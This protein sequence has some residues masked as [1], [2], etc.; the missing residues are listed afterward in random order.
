MRKVVC[1]AE[2]KTL[3]G[4]CLVHEL[5]PELVFVVSAGPELAVEPVLYT[6][7]WSYRLARVVGVGR[8]WRC[9]VNAAIRDQ[10]LGVR[11]EIVK[12]PPRIDGAASRRVMAKVLL[13]VT[14]VEADVAGFKLDAEAMRD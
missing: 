4:G 3:R 1:D 8:A 6:A 12:M 2:G 10:I 9:E 7:P 5:L 11:M 13:P 14:A